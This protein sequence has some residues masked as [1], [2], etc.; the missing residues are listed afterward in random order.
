MTKNGEFPILTPLEQRC[1]RAIEEKREPS[2]VLG[3]YLKFAGEGETVYRSDIRDACL[4]L[5]AKGLISTDRTRKAF[6][7]TLVR[8]GN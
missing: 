8:K 7:Y 5:E 4:A 1:Y 2:T 6:Y 3:L